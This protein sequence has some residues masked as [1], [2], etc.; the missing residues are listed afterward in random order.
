MSPARF[1][2][3]LSAGAVALA[4]LTLWA[5][6]STGGPVLLIGALALGLRAAIA[7]HA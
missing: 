5:A 3:A 6:A 1:V 7:R 2:G 4:A